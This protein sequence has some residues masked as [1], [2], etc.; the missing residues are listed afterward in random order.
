[1]DQTPAVA[2][3]FPPPAAPASLAATPPAA[4]F[5]APPAQRAAAGGPGPLA[6]WPQA[7]NRARTGLPGPSPDAMAIVGART[8]GAGGAAAVA[9]GGIE[10]DAG[11]EAGAATG[12]AAL[13]AQLPGGGWPRRALT[14]LL[15]ASPGVVGLRLL[16]PALAATLAAG[17][18]VMLFDPP[19]GL[20]AWAL[21]QLGLDAASCW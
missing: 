18:S 21:A 7:R 4:V 8:A 14:E 12:F 9:G 16:A 1:M 5:A 15:P 2:A 11:F 3:V 10:V 20:T 19:A 13:D 17:R 6:L